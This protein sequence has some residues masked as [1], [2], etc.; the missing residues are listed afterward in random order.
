M[1]TRVTDAVRSAYLPLEIQRLMLAGACP[2][3]ELGIKGN[4]LRATMLVK[5][6]PLSRSYLVEILYRLGRM[7]ETI[8]RCPRL[9]DFASGK[10]IPH[11][12]SETPLRLCLF[13]NGACDWLPNMLLADTVLCWAS[14]WLFHFEHWEFTGEWNG[15]GT[16]H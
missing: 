9:L 4:N 13:Y 12:W 15:G 5:P 8:V 7:P 3:A 11:I 2:A 1:K 6:S 16:V 14:E 10:R